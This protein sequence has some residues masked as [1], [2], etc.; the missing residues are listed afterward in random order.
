MTT[1]PSDPFS[2]LIHMNVRHHLYQLILMTEVDT[3]DEADL[4]MLV[5]VVVL[6]LN[7]QYCSTGDVM[8]SICNRAAD[9]IVNLTWSTP[10]S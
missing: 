3:K 6:E 2:V 1:P 10:Y 7:R 8:L 5:T 4:A 9:H